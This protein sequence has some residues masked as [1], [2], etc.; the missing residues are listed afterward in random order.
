MDAVI[1]KESGAVLAVLGWG[2]SIGVPRFISPDTGHEYGGQAIFYPC[3]AARVA[4]ILRLGSR[5]SFSGR[6]GASDRRA[7]SSSTMSLS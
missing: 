1:A 3:L 2:R 5:S 6:V 7:S 4:S